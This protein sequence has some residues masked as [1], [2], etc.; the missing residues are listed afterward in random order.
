M[1]DENSYMFTLTGLL[2]LAFIVVILNFV[3]LLL[4]S[5]LTEMYDCDDEL[6]FCIERTIRMRKMNT[7]ETY[8]MFE[9][10]SI[11]S[12]SG[13]LFFKFFPT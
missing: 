2:S 4:K 10:Y 8:R 12:Q 11:F 7:Y 5:I 1:E 6:S 13:D 3:R 9:Q